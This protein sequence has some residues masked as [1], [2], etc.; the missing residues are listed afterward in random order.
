MV[1]G[2]A[3]SA[4]DPRAIK[5]MGVTYATTPQGADHTTGMT[6]RAKIKHT[7][8]EGQVEKSLE[9]QLKMAGYDLLV[10]WGK[11]LRNQDLLLKK[12][13]DFDK[14]KGGKKLW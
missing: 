14:L 12:I 2:Q 4:Y 9:A 8:T 11:D 1:K 10:I 6:I 5:G 7:Q 3:I 13:L